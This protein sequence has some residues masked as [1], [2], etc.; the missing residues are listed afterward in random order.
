MLNPDYTT[1]TTAMDDNKPHPSV[2]VGFV[3]QKKPDDKKSVSYYW[4]DAM[5]EDLREAYNRTTLSESD[6]ILARRL[7]AENIQH[8]TLEKPAPTSSDFFTSSS[9][10]FKDLATLFMEAAHQN[11]KPAPA[12][13][14]R[15]RTLIDTLLFPEGGCKMSDTMDLFCVAMTGKE[16]MERIANKKKAQCDTI[17][18]ERYGDAVKLVL[19]NGR[20]TARVRSSGVW[21]TSALATTLD[22]WGAL[23]MEEGDRFDA[24]VQRIF[25]RKPRRG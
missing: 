24:E 22:Q 18:R 23:L 6:C 8:T 25:E 12:S 19:L 7:H 3:K 9:S 11:T 20:Y 10:E 17:I 15:G 21:Y 14:L 1:T 4:N 13:L 5:R 16:C 2:Y